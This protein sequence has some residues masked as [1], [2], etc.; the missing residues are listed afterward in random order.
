MK[1]F[2]IGDIDHVPVK[3]KGGF[4]KETLILIIAVMAVLSVV[5]FLLR[6]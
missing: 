5:Y 4:H 6:L 1:N 2:Y 3:A